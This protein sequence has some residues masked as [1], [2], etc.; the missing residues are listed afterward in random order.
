MT[1]CF[2]KYALKRPNGATDQ[3]GSSD[4]DSS[5]AKGASENGDEPKVAKK[6]KAVRSKINNKHLTKCLV[7]SVVDEFGC[8]AGW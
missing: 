4:N 1:V 7:F 5:Q 2:R 6:K 3:E 8:S